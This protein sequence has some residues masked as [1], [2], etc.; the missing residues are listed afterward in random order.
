MAYLFHYYD[1]YNNIL[2]DPEVIQS[3][4]G[5]L[6][7]FKTIPCM[8]ILLWK[9][10]KIL[11]NIIQYIMLLRSDQVGQWPSEEGHCNNMYL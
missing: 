5:T 6:P 3:C 8:I 9:T 2:I 11:L 1:N 10:N 4:L 7:T